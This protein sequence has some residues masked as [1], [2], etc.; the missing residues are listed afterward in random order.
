M[1][2]ASLPIWHLKR[3]VESLITEE[4]KYVHQT[5]VHKIQSRNPGNSVIRAQCNR[6]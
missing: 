6:D 4:I 2:Q 3:I 1:T 5:R